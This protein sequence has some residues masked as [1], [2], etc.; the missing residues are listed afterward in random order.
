MGWGHSVPRAQFVLNAF[1]KT[2][3]RDY[4]AVLIV[5]AAETFGGNH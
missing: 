2:A 1:E 5:H 4:L 3:L